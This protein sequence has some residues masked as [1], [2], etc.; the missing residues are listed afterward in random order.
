MVMWLGV[1]VKA[2]QLGGKVVTIS[3]SKGFCNMIQLVSILM[4]KLTIY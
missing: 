2:T 1:S 3:G 4:R